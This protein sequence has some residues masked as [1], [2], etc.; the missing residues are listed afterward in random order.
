MTY[1]RV[2]YVLYTAYIRV[3]L[4]KSIHRISFGGV[5]TVLKGDDWDGS[6][7]KKKAL[8]HEAARLKYSKRG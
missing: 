2:T 7:Q 6:T 1:I 8:L 4:S 3:I 5:L